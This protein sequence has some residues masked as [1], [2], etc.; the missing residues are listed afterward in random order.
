[1]L[2]D[3]LNKFI[4]GFI[5]FKKENVKEKE[6]IPYETGILFSIITKAAIITAPFYAIAIP[7]LTY[8]SINNN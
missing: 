7:L 6:N 5:D 4:N 3:K 8:Y 2:E 1:M